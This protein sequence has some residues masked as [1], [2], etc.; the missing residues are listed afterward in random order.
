M[1]NKQ[2]IAGRAFEYQV[3]ATWRSRG[4]SVIRASGSKGLYDIVAFRPDRKPELIQCKKVSSMATGDR[5][6]SKF[7]K[8]IQPSD[9]YHQVM[10]IKV[11]GQEPVISLTI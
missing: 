6:F 3:M 4:Y 1:P 7:T 10:A 5:L 8:T 9:Y 11:K 2:Y